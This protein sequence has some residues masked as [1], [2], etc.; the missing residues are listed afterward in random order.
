MSHSIIPLHLHLL[1]PYLPSFY[2]V[3]ISPI[4]I[5][6]S[7]LQNHIQIAQYSNPDLLCLS[8]FIFFSAFTVDTTPIVTPR[9]FSS[10]A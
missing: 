10:Q 3:L 5:I 9:A 7:D 8:S 4:A 2:K 6:L 1:K